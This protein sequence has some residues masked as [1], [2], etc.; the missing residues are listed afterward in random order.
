VDVGVAAAVAVGVAVAVAEGVG[1]G[2]DVVNVTSRRG[3]LVPFS[4][5]ANFAALPGLISLPMM[6]HPKLLAGLETHVCTSAINPALL[7]T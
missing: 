4:L 3:G 1:V 6:N 7:Q 5:V 2:G